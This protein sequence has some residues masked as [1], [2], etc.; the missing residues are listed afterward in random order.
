MTTKRDNQQKNQPKNS[1][2]DYRFVLLTAA[3]LGLIYL[4]MPILSPFIVALVLAYIG[5][6]MV[7]KLHQIQLGSYKVGRGIAAFLVISLMSAALLLVIFIVA[8]LFQDELVLFIDRIPSIVEAVK[9][10]LGPWL[11]EHLGISIDIDALELQSVLNQNWKAASQDIG[12]LILN[13]SSRG[14]AVISWVGNAILIPVVLFYLIRDWHTFVDRII[15]FI[16]RRYIKQA[17]T[18]TSE[19]NQVLSGFLHGEFIVML[20]M[21]VFYATGLWFVGMDLA[22]PIGVMTGLLIF[23]PYLG[24]GMGFSLALLVAALQYG[25][26]GDMVPMLIV[27]GIGQFLESF[28]LT[29]LW[30][31]ERIGLHPA[32]VLFALL[33]CGQLFGF[34]GLFFALPLSASIA[35]GL[36]YAEAKY[37]SSNAYLK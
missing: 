4:L 33:A 18:I 3:L 30:I 14:L 29:P 6:P 2:F 20:T 13:L 36:K 26:L 27:F 17:T 24:F 32:V 7:D 25:N 22:I 8:P 5:H 31:G 10:L 19:I 34:I 15:E 11:K 28:I 12:T 1:G 23:I 9:S 37:F 16:P 35:V 21:S